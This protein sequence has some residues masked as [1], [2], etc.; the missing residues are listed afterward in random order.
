MQVNHTIE[1]DQMPHS[2]GAFRA[3]KKI[4]HQI[5]QITPI[6]R[7][8]VGIQSVLQEMIILEQD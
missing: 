2:K 4:T 3:S 5:G 8:G 7:P 1:T 6:S